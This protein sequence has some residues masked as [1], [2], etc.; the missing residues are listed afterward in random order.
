MTLFKKY[1]PKNWIIVSLKWTLW[2]LGIVLVLMMNGCTPSNTEDTKTS[3]TPPSETSQNAEEPVEA[4]I[5]KDTNPPEN[6][7]EN[8]PATTENVNTATATETTTEILP[9]SCDF[10]KQTTNRTLRVGT[11]QNFKKPSDAAAIAQD[12]DVVLIDSGLYEGDTA[13]WTANNLTLCAEG[14]QRAHL[15]ATGATAE[16]KAIWVIKGNDTTVVNLEFSKATSTDHNGAGIRQEGVNLTIR[17][18][19]FHDN[20]DGILAG[21]NPNS[22]LLIEHSEFAGNGYGDGLSHNI[23]INKIKKFIIRYSYSHHTKIG[24]NI[25]SRAYRNYILYNR[26]MD[27]DTGQ[28]SYQ[29]DLP[30]GGLSYIIGN[31]IQQGMKNENDNML[32]YGGEKITNHNPELYV[33][34][35]TFSNDYYY[36]DLVHD[37]FYYKG[38]HLNIYSQAKVT[39]KNNLFMGVYELYHVN[40]EASVEVRSNLIYTNSLNHY[41]GEYPYPENTVLTAD[42]NDATGI[43]SPV[44]VVDKASYD[45]RITPTSDSRNAGI[46]PGAAHGFSLVPQYHYPLPGQNPTRRIPEGTLDIGAYEVDGSK[47]FVSERQLENNHNPVLDDE[48]P[49]YSG[50]WVNHQW[51]ASISLAEVSGTS[52]NRILEVGPGRTYQTPSQA[53]AVA[54]EGDWIKIDPGTYENDAAIWTANNLRISGNGGFVYLRSNGVTVEGK[55]IWVIKGDHTTVENIRFSGASVRDHNGAGIRQ[56]GTDL[57]IRSCYFHDN[58]DGIL[59]GDN[60]NS[61]ILIEHSEFARN[62]YE[63]GLSHNI[64]INKIKKLIIRYSYSHHTKVGHNIKSRAY[65]NYILYNRIMDEDT[66]RA[67][68]QIDLPNGGLSYII[69]N[70]IQQ[71]MKNEN[72]SLISYGGEK[73]TNHNP[74]L[75]VSNNTFSNDYYYHDSSHDVYYYKGRHLNIY[76]RA[77]VTLKNN[78]FMGVYDLYHVNGEAS[79]EVR[80]NLIYTNS[81][82]HYNGE[83]PY[84]ENTVLTAD[85]NDATGVASPVPVENKAAYDYRITPTSEARNAGIPPGEAH[86]FSLVPQYHYPL[87]GQNP[88]RRIPEGTLDIGAYE[89]DGSEA[90]VADRQLENNHNPVL[91]DEDPSY[92]GPWVDH[93]WTVSVPLADT[94]ETSNHRVLEVGPGKIYQTPSQAAAVAQDGDWIKIDPGIYESDAAIWTA[95]DLRISGNGGFVYLKSNGVTVEG[96]AIWVIKGNNTTVENIR[97]SGASVP[98]RNGAGIRQEGTDLIIRSCYFHDNEDGILAGDNPNS[99]ILIEDSEF[100]RNGYEDGLSHNIYINKIK[101]LIIRYSYSHHTKVGHNLKSRAYRNYILYNRIM[102]EDTGR[103]SYQIDLPNGGLSYIIGN[104]IQQGMKNENDSL[105]SY[106]GESITN[107]NPELY[108]INNTFSNDYY[109]HDSSHDVYYYKGRHLNIYSGAKVTLK[110]NLFM[111]V[112]D[113]YHVNG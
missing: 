109:Y 89:V 2:S 112:Y 103:A 39:L 76:A 81:L 77:K 59:A 32:S 65:R 19:Y 45:Y 98:D 88:T 86:D 72:D 83:Y 106:G 70:F 15:K 94:S 108:V 79:V 95:K 82:N 16:N 91:A 101:K 6:P 100:A 113:L 25:K 64:Y 26:I 107:H 3:V 30:N 31:F 13:V 51:T 97:F 104:F 111:G 42:A 80:S 84:P 60:P 78:L 17:N 43:A 10:I 66:G 90:F 34:N 12:N 23:Y 36:H 61:T 24:H 48:D 96:K 47:P 54:Q 29:I 110:N 75:Y 40:G 55:A 62:G 57:I 49:S 27:E 7:L 67:S 5:P 38:R 53:S 11:L 9:F 92:N 37:V 35:N 21:D 87:P 99:T 18:S 102:D 58:E 63:D 14:Q 22:T 85:A 20:E 71:G 28:A 44:P 8:L 1:L 4:S 52:L 41:N 105:I 46:E 73:I 56:E 33:I 69:G 68:Y 50:P 93:Q 74:E